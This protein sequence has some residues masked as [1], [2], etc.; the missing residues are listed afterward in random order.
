MW[1]TK[2]SKDVLKELNVSEK[3]GLSTEEVKKRLEKYGP[4]KLKGKPKKSLLQLFLAQLQ[5]MLIYVL[6][7]AAVINIIAHG[8]DGIADALIILAVVLINAVV[9]VVQE[10]RRKRHWKRCS[11]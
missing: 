7:G 2:S 10:L 9:G 6:I 3:T 11:R 4:N 8:K 1:F 5:D